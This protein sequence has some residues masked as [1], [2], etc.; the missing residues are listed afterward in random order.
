MDTSLFIYLSPQPYSDENDVVPVAQKNV[1]F[2]IG[3]ILKLTNKKI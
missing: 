1:T 3:D 2:K